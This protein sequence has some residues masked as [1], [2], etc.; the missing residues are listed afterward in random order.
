MVRA[1]TE[2]EPLDA[3]VVGSGPN[4]LAAAIH[5]ARAGH[6]VRVLEGHDEVGGGMRSAELTLPGFVHDVCSSVHPLGELSPFLSTLPLA[7]HGLKFVHPP[8]SVAHPLDDGDAVLL[9]RDLEQTAAGLG[10]D[11]P[12]YLRLMEPFV[13]LGRPLLSDLMGPLRLPRH[14]L[15]MARFGFYG[16]R[17]ARRLSR[18]LF[19]K[20]R[21]RALIAGCAAHS[22]LPLT[23]MGTGAVGLLFAL[24]G[25]LC[26]WPVIAGGSGKLAE[27][28]ASYLRSLGG[29][30]E[31]GVMVRDF[32]E[33]PPA[34]VYLFDVAPR[35]LSSIAGAELPEA[36]RR[37]LARYRYG[38]AVFKLDWALSQPIPWRDPA[39]AQASTVHL[40]GTL[41][42]IAA[43][44]AAA[45]RGEHA[46]QPFVLVAQQSHFDPSRAPEGR[47]TGYAYCH[48]PHASQLDV[49]DRIETQIERFAPGFRDCILARHVHSPGDFERYNPAFVGGVIAGGV[50]DLFQLFTRPVAR[51]DPYSTPNPKIF[52]CSA[53]TPPAGGVHGLCG[54]FAAESAL[55]RLGSSGVRG[56][57]GAVERLSDLGG[58]IL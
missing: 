55:K 6:S 24:S 34:R 32:A 52:L 50:A 30:I 3:V 12:R 45:Y 11:G 10:L 13:R 2:S 33:L 20:E 27:A 16:L 5:L 23:T 14:P 19:R 8:L 39:C 53:A 56:A 43:S 51:L 1:A 26:D 22:I 42:A 35:Q 9:G 38:P 7:E 4:G 58:R 40:G 15:A 54:Y 41:D 25:H 29:Q 49:S 57:Q 44:E 17:S 46:E 18:G 21:A 28:M 47:H 48:V 31:T 36:Y 37:R